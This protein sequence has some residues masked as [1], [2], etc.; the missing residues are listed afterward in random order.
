M[1]LAP[2]TLLTAQCLL[3]DM[4]GTL[5]NSTAVVERVWGRWAAGHGIAFDDFR[6]TMHGRRAID[7]M[8][9][10]VP[11]HLDAETE[12]QTI[13]SEELVETDGI[14]PIPG[15]AELLARLPRDRWALVTSAQ[16]PL[17]RVRMGAAGLPM[18]DTVVSADDI[19]EGK[20]NP[21]C[22]L[23]ALDRLGQRPEHAVVFEDAPAGIAAGIAA[24]C[25]T[26]AISGSTHATAGASVPSLVD[27]T[28]LALE[29]ID[30]IAGL[31]L[32]VLPAPTPSV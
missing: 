19:R 4:D 2:G 10:I 8:R 9:G 23:L 17:A 28:R 21:G 30:D 25:R 16:L 22:Y 5:V 14:V 15:A 6:H 13:D 18:P 20:P 26:I 3:F 24:G 29:R 7:I 27:F 1:T 11:P 31:H 12:L 32:R